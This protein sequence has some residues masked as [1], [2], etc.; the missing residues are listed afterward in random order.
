MNPGINAIVEFYDDAESAVADTRLFNG[1]P[2][3]R[4]DGRATE[5]GRLQEL[6]SRLFKGVRSQTE[7]Y[8]FRRARNA[9]L[10]IVG[11]TAIPEWGTSGMSES[12]V[13]GIIGNPWNVGRSPGGSGDHRSLGHERMRR[14]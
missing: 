13:H 6:G 8:F 3:R 5:A 9:G 1:V 12:A 14:K 11:R 2:L 7:S 4:K 10:R